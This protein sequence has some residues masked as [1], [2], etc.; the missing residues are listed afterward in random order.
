MPCNE[1]RRHSV[2]E[3]TINPGLEFYE[4]IKLV[5]YIRSEVKAQNTKPD[6]SSK[7]KFSDDKYLQPVLEDDA[8]LFSID[9]LADT[10]LV[11]KADESLQSLSKDDLVTKVSELEEK[12]QRLAREYSSYKEVAEKTLDERWNAAGDVPA[13]STQGKVP[14]GDLSEVDKG[15]FSSYSFSGMQR[16]FL[17]FFL[18]AQEFFSSPCM[19]PFFD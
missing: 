4:L 9:E 10:E 2:E 11:A 13:I 1:R 8:L 16:S 7:E 3:L 12:L 17:P 15:Y 5:N 14:A 18:Q 6:V 19:K